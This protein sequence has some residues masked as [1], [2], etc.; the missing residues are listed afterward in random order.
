MKLPR[1]KFLHLAAGV[2]ALPA[3]SRVARAQAYPTRPVRIL[4]GFPPAG[5]V[6]ITARLIGQW[7]SERFG[8]QF[9]VEN[10]PGA[11]ANLATETVA[12][13]PPDGYTLLLTSS[14]DAWNATDSGFG[15]AVIAKE[16]PPRDAAPLLG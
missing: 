10:R 6:D 8:Q 5:S 15:E 13:A 3:M 1:R 9:I 2:A 7:L 4:A 12:K 11:G 14:T 16:H